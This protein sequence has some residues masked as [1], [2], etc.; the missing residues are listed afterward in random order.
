[1]A[2]Q[3]LDITSLSARVEHL[4]AEANL[5]KKNI[6][7]L[8]NY[9]DELK[10]EFNSRPELGQLES[11]QGI[12]AQ[13]TE[14]VASLQQRVLPLDETKTGETLATVEIAVTESANT[15]TDES[16][17]KETLLSTQQARL[18]GFGDEEFKAERIMLLLD[19]IYALE[20]E[21]QKQPI[22][23]EEFLRRYNAGER[24]FT[25]INLAGANLNNPIDRRSYRRI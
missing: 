3:E 12:V 18:R 23:T 9:L 19:R 4:E 16:E 7:W 25:E 17:G 21:K 13:L 6:S 1:M 10:Q 20:E 24:D 22:S 8:K 5:R 2:E 14:Q 15:D 11:L